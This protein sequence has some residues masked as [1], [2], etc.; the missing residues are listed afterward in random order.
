MCWEITLCPHPPPSFSGHATALRY[1]YAY[2]GTTSTNTRMHGHGNCGH[3]CIDTA[4]M[5]MFVRAC[6]F[7]NHLFCVYISFIQ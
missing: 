5:V 3:S 4:A 1:E 7:I 2:M 6:S